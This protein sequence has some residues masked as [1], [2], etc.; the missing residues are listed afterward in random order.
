[1]TPDA[2]GFNPSPDYIRGLISQIPLSQREIARRIGVSD[3]YIRAL[4]AGSRE[5]SYP[6]QFCLEVLAD[7]PHQK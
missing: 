7:D 6:V 2:I 1:M 5:C 3:R 4:V